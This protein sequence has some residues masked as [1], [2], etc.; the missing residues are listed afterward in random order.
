MSHTAHEWWNWVSGSGLTFKPRLSHTLN[1]SSGLL[2]S[3][4]KVQTRNAVCSLDFQVPLRH[5]FAVYLQRG[6]GFPVARL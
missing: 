2:F 1:Q 5:L 6:T 4:R 3:F